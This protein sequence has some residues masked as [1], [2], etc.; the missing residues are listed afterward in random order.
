MAFVRPPKHHDASPTLNEIKAPQT[1]CMRRCGL[2]VDCFGRFAQI[3]RMV[4]IRRH[5]V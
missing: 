4:P 1:L 3:A 2:D 5:V